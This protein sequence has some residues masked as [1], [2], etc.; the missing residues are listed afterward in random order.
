MSKRGRI[1]AAVVVLVVIGAIVA[2]MA[3]RAGGSGP[4]IETAQVSKQELAVTVTASGKVEAGIQADV[5]PP[6]QGT[7]DEVYV[8]DGETVTAGAKIAAMDTEPLELQV[9][10]PRRLS[11]RP[12]P[13]SQ[14]ST[15]KLSAPRTSPRPRRTSPPPAKPT[16]QPRRRPPR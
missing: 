10:R 4:E 11:R 13:S 6:T 14:R 9:A 12:R 3:L 8:S 15:T 16:R 7:L 2:F 1:V 5:F